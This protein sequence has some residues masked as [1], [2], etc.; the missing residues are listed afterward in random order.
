LSTSFV[1]TRPS[2]M[3]KDTRV[4]GASA[5]T[6]RCVLHDDERMSVCSGTLRKGGNCVNKATNT[7][8]SGMMPTCRIHRDQLKVSGWCRAPLPCGFECGRLFEWKPHGFQLCP[9]HRKDLTT[10]YFLTI[11]KEMRLRVYQFLLPDR[12]IPAQY[13]NSRALTTDGE[14]V[15]TAILRVNKLIHDEAADLLYSTRVFTIQLSGNGLKMC[16]SASSFVP[17]KFPDHGNHA[18]QDYQMQ[19]MLLEQQNKRRLM[20]ARQEQDNISGGSSS[21]HTPAIRGIQPP[22][23]PHIPYSYGPIETYWRPPISDR[24][25]NVI[26]SFLIEFVFPSPSGPDFANRHAHGSSNAGVAIHKIL[27]S[28]LYD[29]CDH[30]HKLIERLQLIQRP[31]AHLD[32]MIKFGDTYIEREEAFSAAQF[33]LRPFRRLYNVAKPNVLSITMDD[34]LSW[35]TELLIPDWISCTADRT[36]ADYLK[37]WSRDLSSSQP[38][39]ECPQVYKA[40]WKLSELLSSVKEHCYHAEPIFSQFTDLLHAARVAREAEDLTRFKEIWDQVVNIWFDYLNDRKNFQFNVARSIDAI[41]DIVGNDSE[42]SGPGGGAG[43]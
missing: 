19:L 24:C 13:G 5:I 9:G 38:S 39:S 14:G 31:I 40:Y 36:F 1:C 25:F 42:A 27:E 6:H 17:Y 12:R 32:I 22:N 35:E 43:G 30:L 21:T 7:S 4:Y 26:R 10:C 3:A 41:Y 16:N 8:V 18:L 23:R 20:M 11:P 33:L 29:Y 37:C 15:Y 34:F 28:R 2:P